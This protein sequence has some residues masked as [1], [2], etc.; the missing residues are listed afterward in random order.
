MLIAEYKLQ[1]VEIEESLLCLDFKKEGYQKIIN[2]VIMS[3]ITCGCLVGYMMDNRKIFLMFLAFLNIACMLF[4]L[5]IPRFKRKKKAKK[6]SLE[7]G[8]YQ[9]EIQ[10]LHMERA[11]ESENV[12]TIKADSEIYCIPKR[13]LSPE[14]RIQLQKKLKNSSPMFLNVVTG[15]KGFYGEQRKG[16]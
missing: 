11:F 10:N 6:I 8:S 7:K 12:F 5:Y 1:A 13:I 14:E 16:S 15:K 3:F 9:F 2:I 4:I